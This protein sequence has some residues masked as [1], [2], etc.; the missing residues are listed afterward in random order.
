MYN[1]RGI[2]LRAC[3]DIVVNLQGTPRSITYGKSKVYH[4]APSSSAYMLDCNN[5]M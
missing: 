3:V 5:R 1:T 2:P 4:V